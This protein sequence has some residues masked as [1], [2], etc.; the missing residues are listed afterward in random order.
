MAR[1]ER[2]A[3]PVPL[4][5]RRKL[6]RYRSRSTGTKE[7]DLLLAGFA[8]RHLQQFDAAQLDRFE[9][10]LALPEPVLWAWLTGQATPPPDLDTDVLALLKA[11]RYEPDVS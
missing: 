8:A 5:A 6:L 3:M 10:L 2:K 11:Y 1:T 4:E 7:S 9:R